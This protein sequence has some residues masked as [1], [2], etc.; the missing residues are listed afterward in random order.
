MMKQLIFALSVTSIL[1]DAQSVYAA[2]TEMLEEDHYKKSITRLLPRTIEEREKSTLSL[3]QNKVLNFG[4]A[5]QTVLPLKMTLKKKRALKRELRIQARIAKKALRRNLNIQKN[6]AKRAEKRNMIQLKKSK[7]IAR[8]NAKRMRHSARLKMRLLVREKWRAAKLRKKNHTILN[9]KKLSQM[10]RKYSMKKVKKNNITSFNSIFETLLPFVSKSKRSIQKKAST[11]IK[12]QNRSPNSLSSRA[13]PIKIERPNLAVG[14]QSIVIK[15]EIKKSV[16]QPFPS[17]QQLNAKIINLK[18]LNPVREKFISKARLNESLV[19]RAPSS[20]GVRSLPIGNREIQQQEDTIAFPENFLSPLRVLNEAVDNGD[21]AKARLTEI[22]PV[23]V[24]IEQIDYSSIEEGRQS[25][26][27]TEVQKDKEISTQQEEEELKNETQTSI[28]KLLP[29]LEQNI[30]IDSEQL[31]SAQE[32]RQKSSFIEEDSSTV[33]KPSIVV[34]NTPAPEEEDREN[35]IRGEGVLNEALNYVVDRV[36]EFVEGQKPVLQEQEGEV[37]RIETVNLDLLKENAQPQEVA[38]G[39]NIEVIPAQQ[40]EEELGNETTTPTAEAV[41][42]KIEEEPG[43]VIEDTPAPAPQEEDREDP[44]RGEGVLNEALNYVVDRVAEFVGAQ[45]LPHTESQKPISTETF[46]L[47]QEQEEDVVP[48]RN[49]DLIVPM[50]NDPFEDEIGLWDSEETHFQ[51]EKEFKEETEITPTLTETTLPMGNT[52]MPQLRGTLAPSKVFLEGLT[53]LNELLN[54]YHANFEKLDNSILDVNNKVN[55]REFPIRIV[56]LLKSIKK[57]LLWIPEMEK[58]LE[59]NSKRWDGSIAS[60]LSMLMDELENFIPN[61]KLIETSQLNKNIVFQISFASNMI[62]HLLNSLNS[63]YLKSESSKEEQRIVGEKEIGGEEEMD[64]EKEENDSI[65]T[66]NGVLPPLLENNEPYFTV[67]PLEKTDISE[68]GLLKFPIEDWE[69][70]PSLTF[71]PETG[72]SKR[73]ED[74]PTLQVEN[75]LNF[76]SQIKFIKKEIK[77]IERENISFRQELYSGKSAEFI[78]HER[79]RIENLKAAIGVFNSDLNLLTYSLESQDLSVEKTLIMKVKIESLRD[80]LE[81]E[82]N[83]LN[84][85]DQRLE[86][87]TVQPKKAESTLTQA[88]RDPKEIAIDFFRGLT[89]LKEELNF[90]S[91]K[92]MSLDKSK[93]ELEG[94]KANLNMF[95]EFMKNKLEKIEDYLNVSDEKGKER[96]EKGE[97]TISSRLVAFS[98]KLGDFNL[99]FKSMDYSL[100][101]SDFI[102]NM[103]IPTRIIGTFIRIL[104]RV[105][106]SLES[107]DAD[108]KSV[109]KKETTALTPIVE[110]SKTGEQSPKVF[111]PTLGADFQELREGSLKTEEGENLDE[112]AL[113]EPKEIYTPRR[114]AIEELLAIASEFSSTPL[115]YDSLKAQHAASTLEVDGDSEELL[116]K[117]FRS[118][119]DEF[120]DVSDTDF[121]SSPEQGR[122]ELPTDKLIHKFEDQD[123]SSLPIKQF[124]AMVPLQLSDLD[125]WEKMSS[126][127]SDSEDWEVMDGTDSDSED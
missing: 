102:E 6:I 3:L 80:R 125:D 53:N 5:R 21:S 121:E 46:N 34:E 99:K 100:L 59:E 113:D 86:F 8:E 23:S 81:T 42:P 118:L 120:A 103:I 40:E 62:N 37:A 92:L 43:V 127:D 97:E 116:D 126:T 65:F 35:P 71:G 88:S 4:I 77:G 29:S 114:V 11:P 26:G 7:R 10:R 70:L 28:E 108:E 18:I 89:L 50:E 64:G 75:P 30:I 41:V 111:I 74:S 48:I 87:L 106:S 22:I 91:S 39:Q 27:A 98:D 63:I 85:V 109:D 94:D 9:E 119:L 68:I 84:T 25:Q 15:K 54:I 61:F 16:A 57:N 55:V 24:S 58:K 66:G 122:S 19:D 36:A 1:G 93:P 14:L 90:H 101:N 107:F 12:I 32:S 110:W 45:E 44:I 117:S 112:Q 69:N 124:T 76:K 105:L 96:S 115:D 78:H 72:E 56:V 82:K 67:V 17:H 2:R 73:D 83:H 49:V 52:S 79:L 51:G 60:G 38:E 104:N 20:P 33:M 31:K 123:N 47:L 95:I 13:L